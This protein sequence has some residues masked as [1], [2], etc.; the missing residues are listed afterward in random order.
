MKE[1]L[2][3][4]QVLHVANL[5]RIKVDEKEIEKYQVEL[6]QL[7]D[8]VE[9]ITEVEDYDEDIMIAPW[10]HNTTLRKDEEKDMLEA[11]EVLKN[12]PHHSGNYITVPVVIGES[13]GA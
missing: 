13:E 5:A 1:K 3:K 4:E 8:D 11:K 6:K 7:L 9:K 10:D 12:A 2:T